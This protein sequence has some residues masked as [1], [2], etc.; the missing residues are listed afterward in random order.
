MSRRETKKILFDELLE[1][2]RRVVGDIA[3]DAV[4]AA[5]K[6]AGTAQEIRRVHGELA[7]PRLAMSALDR[8]YPGRLGWRW[9]SVAGEHFSGVGIFTDGALDNPRGY[10]ETRLYP[11]LL[12]AVADTARQQREG[13]ARGVAK[14]KAR[15]ESRIAQAVAAHLAGRGI[16]DRRRCYICDKHLTDPVSI[17]RGIG[18]ECWDNILRG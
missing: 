2:C 14:R 12:W 6:D 15:R 16:G 5:A 18:P 11:V 13:V 3:P 8:E 9:I 1:A 10:P 4:L 17:A 7:G